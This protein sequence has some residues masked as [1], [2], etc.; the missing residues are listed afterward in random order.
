MRTIEE[1]WVVLASDT[2]LMPCYWPGG[3]EMLAFIHSHGL[4]CRAQPAEMI[5]QH[6]ANRSLT[7][8]V[9]AGHTRRGARS[10]DRS[11]DN[12]CQGCSWLAAQ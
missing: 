7:E 12:C 9:A 10:V 11:D 1:A 6:E 4:T 3:R 2:Y 5:E 8:Y